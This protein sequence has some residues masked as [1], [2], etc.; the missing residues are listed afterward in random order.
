MPNKKYDASEKLV[1]IGD[2]HLLLRR[3]RSGE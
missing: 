2:V 3:K 1:I